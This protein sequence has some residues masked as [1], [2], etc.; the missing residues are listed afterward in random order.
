MALHSDL[1][2]RC[3][4]CEVIR[5]REWLI[6]AWARRS[7]SGGTKPNVMDHSQARVLEDA[8]PG[9]DQC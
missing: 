8:E 7:R 1:R 3:Q 4:P 2:Q 5:L 9:L 6:E